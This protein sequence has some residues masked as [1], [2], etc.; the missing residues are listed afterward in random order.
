MVSLEFCL[1][2]LLKKTEENGTA[3][4]LFSNTGLIFILPFILKSKY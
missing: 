2:V 4:P 3:E 1:L